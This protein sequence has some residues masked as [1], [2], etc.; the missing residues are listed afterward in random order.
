MNR[1]PTEEMSPR[2]LLR[3]S[4]RLHY[5]TLKYTIL[6]FLIM[7]VIKYLA[8]FVLNFIA[9]SYLKILVEIVAAV[10]IFYCFSAT[11]LTA[12]QAF[13]DKPLLSFK[14]ALK[15]IWFHSREIYATCLIYAAG[16]IIIYELTILT[17]FVVAKFT[18]PINPSTHNIIL[19]VGII[20]LVMY[21][22][23]LYFSVPLAILDQESI[24]K[25]FYR[26]VWLTEKNKVGIF[27]SFSIVGILL[28]LLT[29]GM[30]HEYLLSVYHLDS[31]FDF[32]VLCV[33]APIYINF[34]LFLIHDSKLSTESCPR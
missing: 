16:G 23:M 27:I 26:S 6:F 22:S 15:R 5:L 13:I 17:V 20:L 33:G 34:L 25:S 7:V 1:Y 18:H 31:L 30:M 9:N 21:V 11:L 28:L 8:L 4:V 24:W 14:H 29:P 19:A 32:V 3:R 2:Q 10:M 12:H